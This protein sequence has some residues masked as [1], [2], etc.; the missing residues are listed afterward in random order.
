MAYIG[1][2]VSADLIKSATA[3]TAT[4]E[5][6]DELRAEI[7]KALGLDDTTTKTAL[8]EAKEELELLKADLAAV[9]E[10]AAPG[11]PSLRMSQNQTTKSAQVDQLRA[12][13]D[14]YRRTASQ[15]IDM[16]LRNAYVEKALKLEQ[17]A[18]SIAKN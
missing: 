6:R 5:L 17:D 11:G 1:L 2:G 16:S 13:A 10:M 14:R 12:E 9:K 3:T 4:D 7:V 8:A 18:D 15:I